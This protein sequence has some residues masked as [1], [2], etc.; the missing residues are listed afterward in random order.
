MRNLAAT[1]LG[2]V[3]ATDL[4]TPLTHLLSKMPWGDRWE[5]AS[6]DMPLSYARNSNL[7]RMS[8]DFMRV[9]AYS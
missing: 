9:F 2:L 5:D 8:D 6:L 3:E 1:V 4:T 7:L